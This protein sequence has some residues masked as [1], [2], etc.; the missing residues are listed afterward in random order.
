MSSSSAVFRRRAQGSV[1]TEAVGGAAGVSAPIVSKSGRTCD[2]IIS[3]LP[4]PVRVV[5]FVVV[6]NVL[7]L[8]GPTLKM[9]FDPAYDREAAARATVLTRFLPVVAFRGLIVLA[10]LSA[11]FCCSLRNP[12]QFAL[13]YLV[14]LIL[15]YNAHLG[16]YHD[17]VTVVFIVIPLLELICGSDR[18]NPLPEEE[19]ELVNSIGFR[20]VTWLWVPM[21]LLV[22]VWAGWV[23]GT[24]SLTTWDRVF[25]TLSVGLTGGALSINI[26]HEL[27]HK[28]G[29][30]ERTLGKILLAAVCYG[31]FYVE[32]VWGHHKMVSTPFDPAS[33]RLG[34]SF[35]AFYPRTVIGSFRSAWH[36]AAERCAKREQAVWSMHNEVLNLIVLSLGFAAGMGMLFGKAAV[37]FF[38][39]QSVVAFSILEL[40]NYIE[41]Y[42]L[43]RKADG[44]NGEFEAVRPV[45][46]WNADTRITNLFLF[47]LQRHSDHHANAGRRYQILRTF[48]E[49]L[50]GQMPTGY[51]GMIVLALSTWIRVVA[52]VRVC[53]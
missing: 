51:G 23:I 48:P 20:L 36:L 4:L 7:V 41:H 18:E 40:V 16:S 33:S 22:L 24:W 38:A 46:S 5:M 27:I 37:V 39:C 9:I 21:Q 32:H 45:H 11:M 10:S 44:S 49:P 53:L 17:I 6:F 14:P 43:E 2:A 1:K 35:Y 3:S 47:K 15:V 30:F 19:S 25:F 52:C 50:A 26:A 29:T 28:A 42:G 12:M 8:V 34:E 13:A 31:W